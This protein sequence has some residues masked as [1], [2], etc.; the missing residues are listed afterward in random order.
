MSRYFYILQGV[1]RNRGWPYYIGRCMHNRIV[2]VTYIS[3]VNRYSED[4]AEWIPNSFLYPMFEAK[5]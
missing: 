1:C 3:E 2:L 5:L 4:A